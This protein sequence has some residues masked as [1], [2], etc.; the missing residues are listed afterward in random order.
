MEQNSIGSKFVS[1][2]EDGLPETVQ[3]DKLVV[4]LISA[5]RKLRSRIDELEARLA[6]LETDA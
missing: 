4:P 6:E 5:M 2:N 1:H 3:Y